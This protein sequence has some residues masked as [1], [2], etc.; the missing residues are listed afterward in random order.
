MHLENQLVALSILYRVRVIDDGDDKTILLGANLLLFIST[1]INF[2]LV[3]SLK[4]LILYV[5]LNY[6][7]GQGFRTS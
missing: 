4:Y 3:Y 1:T 6:R 2:F 7:I 5:S